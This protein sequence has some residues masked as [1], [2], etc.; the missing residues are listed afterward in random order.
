MAYS[1]DNEVE[2][3]SASD[4]EKVSATAGTYLYFS[5]LV[6]AE[7]DHLEKEGKPQ[8]RNFGLLMILMKGFQMLNQ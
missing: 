8:V 5:G 4:C 7:A 6:A 1:H 2:P 3:W